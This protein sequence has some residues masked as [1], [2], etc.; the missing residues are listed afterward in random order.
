M[1]R[2]VTGIVK[3]KET[4]LYMLP[5]HHVQPDTVTPRAVGGRPL[6]FVYGTL[7]SPWGNNVLLAQT[8]AKFLGYDSITGQFDM[9]SF[10]GFPGVV[11]GSEENTP[12]RIRGEVW[13]V[14]EEGLRDCDLLEGHPNWYERRK[15]RTDILDVRAWMYTLP[16]TE[17]YLDAT[18]HPRVPS[19]CWRETNRENEHWLQI[20]E[21]PASA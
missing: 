4:G 10:G 9:I 19:G 7:K 17:R 11:R 3:D 5:D 21:S 8:K 15:Y 14:D 18:I 20:D 2:R 12:L 1:S 6:I 13:A 16:A